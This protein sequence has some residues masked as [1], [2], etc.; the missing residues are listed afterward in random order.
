MHRAAG[1]RHACGVARA[2]RLLGGKRG[3]G[4]ERPPRPARSFFWRVRPSFSDAPLVADRLNLLRAGVARIGIGPTRDVV[5]VDGTVSEGVVRRHGRRRTQGTR[6]STRARSPRGVYLRVTRPRYAPGGRPRV[7]RTAAMREVWAAGGCVSCQPAWHLPSV[8]PEAQLVRTERG[9]VPTGRGLV[10][11]QRREAQWSERRDAASSAGSRARDE[12]ATDFH[13][14]GFNL[15][16]LGRASRWR[17]TT[18]S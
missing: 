2:G 15:T 17:C 10:R 14:L 6:A 5:L 11:S 13:Q 4:G 7:L 16:L 18:G 3:R 9:L 12:G 1:R 8:I